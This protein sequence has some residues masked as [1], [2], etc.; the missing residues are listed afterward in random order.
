MNN[1]SVYATTDDETIV[2][3]DPDHDPEGQRQLSLV[4]DTW[5][6]GTCE[7]RLRLCVSCSLQLF[8]GKW[9]RGHSIEVYNNYIED[10]LAWVRG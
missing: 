6:P 5:Y 7:V 9:Y 10:A 2:Y 3:T 4:S 8:N 1:N